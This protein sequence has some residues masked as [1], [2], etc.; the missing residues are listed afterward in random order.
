MADLIVHIAMS[1]FTVPLP[2]TAM[3]GAMMLAGVAA[4]VRSPAH[5]RRARRGI[6]R[7]RKD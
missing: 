7:G 3:M 6:I 4:F 5:K 2:G 1:P